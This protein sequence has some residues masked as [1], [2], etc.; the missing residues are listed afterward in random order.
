[1]LYIAETCNIM[2]LSYCYFVNWEKVD[3]WLCSVFFCICDLLKFAFLMPKD[4]SHSQTIVDCGFRFS[5][6]KPLLLLVSLS[7][8]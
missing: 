7:L 2:L 6:S 8:F 3:C 4:A 5:R 1:M